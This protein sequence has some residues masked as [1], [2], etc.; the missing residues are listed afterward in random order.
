MGLFDYRDP[1]CRQTPDSDIRLT[2]T[3][4]R[5]CMNRFEKCHWNAAN[6]TY[7]LSID[8]EDSKTISF[9]EQQ[10]SNAYFSLF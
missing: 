10:Q 2:G 7:D 1:K 4:I 3:T 6:H 5:L 8:I 9:I